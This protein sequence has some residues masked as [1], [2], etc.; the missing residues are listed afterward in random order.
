MPPLPA[1]VADPVL[2]PLQSTFVCALILAPKAA[3]S[4][5]V[6]VVIVGPQ[7]FASVTLTV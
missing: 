1:P 5:N 3:G 7:P 2:L 6:T 4:V